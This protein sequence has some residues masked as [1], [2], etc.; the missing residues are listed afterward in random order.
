MLVVSPVQ[1][2]TSFWGIKSNTDLRVSFF[3]D[4]TA[5][6]CSP[7][8]L[9]LSLSGSFR[10]KQLEQSL[11]ESPS[12]VTKTSL[13]GVQDGRFQGLQEQWWASWSTHMPPSTAPSSQA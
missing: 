12:N 7:V 11:R 9:V 8:S 5:T 4:F 1:G 2:A 3:G 6:L 10:H 13:T